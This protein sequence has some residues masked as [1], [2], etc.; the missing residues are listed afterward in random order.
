[1]QKY[2]NWEPLLICS[3]PLPIIIGYLY[4]SYYSYY[5]YYYPMDPTIDPVLLLR[6]F[7]SYYYTDRQAR[8]LSTN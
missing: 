8:C 2:S 1:M 7:L 5:Y 4:Y 3:L 6:S